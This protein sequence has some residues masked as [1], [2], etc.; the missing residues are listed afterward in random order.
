ML[1]NEVFRTRTILYAVE[2]LAK[3]VHGNSHAI[4]AIA[5]IT[6]CSLQTGRRVPLLKATP[7]QF[8]EYGVYIELSPSLH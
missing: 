4:H 5:S 8:T 2:L 7:T 3:S 6:C 1:P